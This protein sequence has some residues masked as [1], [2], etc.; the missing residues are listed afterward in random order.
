M[1]GMAVTKFD[2]QLG[3]HVRRFAYCYLMFVPSTYKLL[4]QGSSTP[5]KVVVWFM[6]PLLRRLIYRGLGCNKPGNKEKSL[7]VIDSMFKEVRITVVESSGDCS[8]NPLAP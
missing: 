6:M 2:D 3:P 1:I 5:E 7:Q 8:M 4:T